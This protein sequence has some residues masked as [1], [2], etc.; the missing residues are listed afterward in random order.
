MRDQWINVGFEDDKLKPYA[1]PSLLVDQ[2][3]I[4]TLALLPDFSCHSWLTADFS[5]F[6]LTRQLADCPSMLTGE[7]SSDASLNT[8]N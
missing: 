4:G 8:Y 2:K 7:L 3:R 6:R 5:F 1:E